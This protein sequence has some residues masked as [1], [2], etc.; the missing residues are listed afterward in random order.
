MQITTKLEQNICK[1]IVDT[2]SMKI[3][4]A[5]GFTQSCGNVYGCNFLDILNTPSICKDDVL[6][7]IGQADDYLFIELSGRYINKHETHDKKVIEEYCKRAYPHVIRVIQS[8]FF[9]K[10][11]YDLGLI[12]ILKGGDDELGG[13]TNAGHNSFPYFFKDKNLLAFINSYWYGDIL[14]T[15]E[16]ITICNH[17]F[18]SS[19]QIRYEE[20]MALSKLALKNSDTAL[21]QARKSQKQTVIV[22]LLVLIASLIGSAVISY[23]VPS[24][25]S[26]DTKIFLKN[27]VSKVSSENII[28]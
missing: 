28:K 8:L 18:K 27:I 7:Y 10:R 13:V 16:L 3:S 22:S 19:D 15:E 25:F 21:E 11:L 6:T 17:E 12:I 5:D 14:P 23:A 9:L 24:S 20:E 1:Y 2:Y 26:N 4:Q